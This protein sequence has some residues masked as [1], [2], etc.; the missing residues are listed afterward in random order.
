MIDTAIP[1]SKKN[2]T[3]LYDVFLVVVLLAGAY[4]RLTGSDWGQLNIQHPDE[5]FMTSVTL[6]IKPVHNL[7]DYFNTARSTLNPAVV[8]YPAYVYGTLPLFIVHYLAE[9]F[10]K[11]NA[12]TLFGRQLSAVADLGTIALLYFIVRRFYNARVAL[13]A[14]AFSALA[15]MQIQ[16]SHFYTTDSFSTFFMFLTLSVAAVIATGDWKG[17]G[18]ESESNTKEASSSSRLWHSL[19]RLLNDPLIYLTIV[20]GITLGMAAA[21]KLNA[22]VVAVVLPLS[23]VVRYFKSHQ[24]KSNLISDPDR[25]RM[26]RTQIEDFI[27]KAIVFL[28]LGAVV[29]LVAFRVFQPYA[30]NGP[31]FFGIKFN[32]EWVQKIRE[33]ILQASPNADLPWDL[34]WAR[35]NHLYSFQNLTVWGLG[36]PLGILAWAGFLWMGWRMLKGEWRQHLL[37]W[38][39]TAVYFIWQS[40]QY[41]PTMR[42]QLPVYPLL[43]MMAA[44]V[45]YDWARPRLSE[46]KRLNWRAILSATVGVLVLAATAA[47]AFAFSRIY[48]RPETRITASNWIYQN[49]P[50]PINLQIQ[51]ANGPVYQQPLPFFA[52]VDIRPESPYTTVFTAQADGLLNQVFLPYAIAHDASLT[53]DL[54]ITIWQT[55][56]DP[57]PLAS[58]RLTTS[59]PTT[60][61]ST[62]QSVLF[63]QAPALVAQQIYYIKVESLTDTAQVD[64]CGPLQL[65]FMTANGAVQQTLAS[66]PQCMVSSDQPYRTQFVAQSDGTLTQIAF[67]HV[68]DITHAGMKTVSLALASAPNPQPDQILAKATATADFSPTTNPRG[69]PITLRLETPFSLQRGVTYYLQIQTTGGVLTLIGAAVANE[70]DYDYPLPFRTASYDAFGGIYPGGLNLQVYWEDNADKLARIQN[71]LDQAD[72]IF[73]PTNHQYA[74][75]TRIPERYPLTTEYYRQLIGCPA[76]KNIIWCYRMAEPGMFHGNLGFDLVATFESYPNIGPLVINDQAA[77]EAFT[78]YDHPK[79]LIFQKSTNYDPAIVQSVLG[80][81]DFSRAIHLTPGQ[82]DDYKD[83]M[84]SADQLAEQ[85]AGGTWSELFNRDALQNKYPGLGLVLWYLVIFLVGLFAFPLVR[86][87]LPGLADGG[88]PL[89]RIAGLLLWAWLVWMAGS[90]GIPFNKTTI[91]VALGVVALVGVWQAWR[92]RDAL[93]AEWGRRWKFYLF[94]ELLFLAFFLLDLLIRLG[95][96]DLWHPSK[97]G[98]RPMNFAQLNAILKSTT[99]PPYDPW[100]AGGYINYYYFGEVIVGMPVKLL[101][102]VPSIAFNFILPTLFAIVATAA[103]SVGYNLIKPRLPDPDRWSLKTDSWP[104]LTGFSA[105]AVMVLLGNLGVVRLFVLGFQRNAAPGGVIEGANLLEKIWWTVKGFVVTLAGL[106]LPYGP[107]DWYWF[108]SRIFAYPHDE[109]YEFPAFTFLWSDLH[110]HLI[111]FMLTI[112]VIAWV[113]SLLLSKARWGSKT[114]AALGLFLGALVIGSLKPTNTWDFYTY[115]VFGAAALFYTVARYSKVEHVFPGQPDWVKRLALA[116]GAVVVLTAL[117]LLFYQPFSHWF[118]QAYSSIHKWTGLRTPVSTYLVQWGLLLFFI[119]SWMAWETRQWLAE[120]PVSALRKLRPYRDLILAALVIVLLT[121]VVQQVWVMLPNQTPPWKDVTI[122]WLAL[123]LALWAAVLLLFRHGISDMKRLVLFMTGTGL[124]LTMMV[125]LVVVAGDI[126]RM[127]TI[128]KFGIQS[129]VLLGISAAASFGWLMLELRKWLPG[130][131]AIWQLMATILIIGAALFLPVAGLNKMRDRWVNTAPHTLDSMDYMQYAR[132]SEFGRD[133]STAEDYR[134]ILWMQENIQ[135]SPVIV[136]AAP[137][138]VQYTWL[139]RFSIYTGLPSVVGW[140]WHEQQQ[141]VN[142]SG[143]VIQRGVDVDNFY[144]TTDI[145]YAVNFLNKYNVRYIIIGQLELGKYTPAA[146]AVPS[147]LLKFEQ[148]DGI[149]WNEVYRDGQTVIYEVPIGG[150]VNP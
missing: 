90:N 118:G 20:F 144:N 55:P 100:Y 137:A 107:G 85:Q 7:S 12:V 92:Q 149:F 21:S 127:N 124:F 119:V 148:F 104:V 78:F 47:Y 8:G 91:A 110:A 134:A 96:P 88:Y 30:F 75:I 11:L 136:E 97:G 72:Y 41:N 101:G 32:P 51:P 145:N 125:E 33:Q 49:V 6:A 38:S 37:L 140:Q 103:F 74:Q 4:L 63:D 147:G 39:W 31:G 131:R 45:V 105:S 54:R 68:D 9:S 50:G 48:V 22:A 2:F 5:N 143:Q 93:K 1:A 111:A 73:I 10:G 116:G 130:W 53:V 120:T 79:V 82:A 17:A 60:T 94:L 28:V 142:F 113:V 81:V 35:R 132:Y 57:Q 133:F 69:D 84:L 24:R 14:A 112:L 122:L 44:W 106:P 139:S 34:Q 46:L 62:S 23:L 56:D 89:A 59:I 13:L 80:K 121:L 19:L 102:I 3:W 76:D 117:S 15:V 98:E 52:G 70:T 42:Y 71:V 77:E 36:L 86:A 135:G 95:N 115:S 150:E 114:D 43:A 141:R 129:W 27:P 66:I 58:G 64:V 29:S 26:D 138:G 18:L 99:F 123:P 61:G 83:L 108:S 126:G 87:A 65:F 109:F 67:A 16:Q 128:Y 25:E 146:P 40:L